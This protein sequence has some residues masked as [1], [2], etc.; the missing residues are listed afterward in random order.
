MNK[1][2]GRETVFH[3]ES[4][5]TELQA[6]VSGSLAIFCF[7]FLTGHYLGKHHLFYVKPSFP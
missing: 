3:Y 4:W 6:D 5:S 2:K 7:D 1:K